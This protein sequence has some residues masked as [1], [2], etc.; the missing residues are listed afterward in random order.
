M[1][2][3]LFIV[4][5]TIPPNNTYDRWTPRTHLVK[6]PEGFSDEEVEVKLRAVADRYGGDSWSSDQKVRDFTVIPVESIEDFTICRRW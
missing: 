1:P 6:N 3:D 4:T 2:T 5:Y